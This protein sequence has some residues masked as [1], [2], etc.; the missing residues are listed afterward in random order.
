MSSARAF[1]AL[2]KRAYH[3]LSEWLG[4]VVYEDPWRAGGHNG[5]SNS[6][7]PNEP[8]P[9]YPRVRQLRTTMREFGLDDTAII[10]AGGVWHLRD[11]RDWLDNAE[12]G[13]IGFQFGTRP[14]LTR[15]SPISPAWK[16]RL[17]ELEE[18]D[19]L[20]HRFSPDRLLFLRGQQRLPAGAAGA[21]RTP[22]PVRR[23]A[24]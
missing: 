7:N 10:M 12:L 22:D 20:L 2:W 17:L 16:R 21:L 24:R 3:R 8:E 13:P 9:P 15:E 11:W 4:G 18:G 14:L 23:G 19:V 6:E 1:R 5:L